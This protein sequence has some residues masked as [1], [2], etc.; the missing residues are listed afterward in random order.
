MHLI[1]GI[2]AGAASGILRTILVSREKV[3]DLIPVDVAINVMCSAAWFVGSRNTVA[4]SQEIP[5]YNCTSGSINPIRWGQI[6]SWGLESILKHPLDTLLWYPGGSFKTSP[7]YDRVCRVIFHYIPAYIVDFV[8]MV[9]R[10]KPFMKSIVA[11]M[12]KGME[13]LE[14]FSTREW[15]WDA[16]NLENLGKTV[17]A[18]GDKSDTMFYFDIKSLDWVPFIEKYVLGTRHFVLKNKPETIVASRKKLRTYHFAHILVQVF[19]VM[20]MYGLF[21]FLFSQ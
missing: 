2:I 14:Y 19:F 18:I 15:T 9:L 7:A 20:F 6:E 17:E 10:K 8:M 1:S 21:L 13:A 5:I 16:S 12:T 3:A 4:L 11:K